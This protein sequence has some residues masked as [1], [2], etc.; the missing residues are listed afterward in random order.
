MYGSTVNV[1]EALAA[2]LESF[3]AG[4]ISLQISSRAAERDSALLFAHDA[5]PRLRRDPAIK[6]PAF[7]ARSIRRDIEH[8]Q[9]HFVK[10]DKI[11]IYDSNDASLYRC[12][13]CSFG[14]LRCGVQGYESVCDVL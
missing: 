10:L 7:Q 14:L 5:K 1:H 9:L 12:C 3:F 2:N 6:A 4:W 11:R 13:T 8:H